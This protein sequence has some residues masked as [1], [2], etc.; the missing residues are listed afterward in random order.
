MAAWCRVPGVLDVYMQILTTALYPARANVPSQLLRPSPLARHRGQR[1]FLHQ[2]MMSCHQNE[3]DICC[4][5]PQ[6]LVLFN[7]LRKWTADI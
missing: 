6:H 2:I 4:S 7:K 1:G 5:F 3:Y